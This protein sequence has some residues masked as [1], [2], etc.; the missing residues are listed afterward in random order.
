M[1]IMRRITGYIH[2]NNGW[3]DLYW[4]H[5]KILQLLGTV[6]HKQGKLFGRMLGLGFDLRS[7]AMLQTLTT[8]V[9]K[10]NEIEGEVLSH[11]QV[12]SSVA[13]RLGIDIAG[14]VRSGRH[15]EG[16]VEMM[17]DATQNFDKKL[18]KGRLFG[19]HSALF[20]SAHSGILKI[21][22]GKWRSD[23]RGPMQVVSGP[24]GREHVHFEA[25]PAS[26]LEEQMMEFLKWFNKEIPIDP[27]LKAAIAHFW[28][29]TIHPFEDGNGRMA[30]A[31]TDMLLARAED[32]SQRFYSMSAQILRERIAYYDILESTQKGSLDISAWIEWFLKC[33]GRSVESS[34]QT[35]ADIMLKAG[36]WEAHASTSFNAR[37]QLMLNKLLDGFEG[38][39]VSSKWARITKCSPDTALRDIQEL[40]DLG[41]LLKDG[42]GGRSTSYSLAP[43]PKKQ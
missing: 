33:L 6:R 13:R 28:F 30:R 5:E 14:L 3:P 10:S 37:Q 20:P 23:K 32:S 24:A 22:A 11:D 15:V 2:Q 21:S 41:I 9:L 39:L 43:L 16:V 38:K 18:T 25:P 12:R 7:E 42:A 35:L 26:V 31:I 36:F 27:V 4:S 40:M 17:L 34:E 8:D 29:V 1:Q 19:W